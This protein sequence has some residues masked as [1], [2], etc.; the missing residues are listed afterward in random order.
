MINLKTNVFLENKIY[1]ELIILKRNYHSFIDV[2]N[3]I[4]KV[5]LFILYIKIYMTKKINKNMKKK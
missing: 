4:L 2:E 3:I 5:F 1:K